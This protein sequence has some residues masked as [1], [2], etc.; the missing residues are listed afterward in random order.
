MRPSERIRLVQK[1]RIRGEPVSLI[2]EG[3]HPS[4]IIDRVDVSLLF[5]HG[6]NNIRFS[7]E[8][9]LPLKIENL[10]LKLE[11]S[12]DNFASLSAVAGLRLPYSYYRSHRRDLPS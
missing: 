10:N 2:L 6:E 1:A 11:M 3:Q 8:S 5:T 4:E 9:T 7:G 12:G